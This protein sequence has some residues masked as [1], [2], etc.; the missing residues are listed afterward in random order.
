MITL[1]RD[2]GNSIIHINPDD[3]QINAGILKGASGVILLTKKLNEFFEIDEVESKI[4]F[5]INRVL[6]SQLS[7][8]EVG[9]FKSFY[10]DEKEQSKWVIDTGFLE[11]LSGIGLTFLSLSDPKLNDWQKVLLL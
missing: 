6:S 5:W 4:Q 8:H 10:I 3:N 11:G 7:K 2:V 1:K 9:D